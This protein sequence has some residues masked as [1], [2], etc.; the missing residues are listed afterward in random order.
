[1]LAE[2]YCPSLFNST[3]L[4][5]DNTRL[6]K[7]EQRARMVFPRSSWIAAIALHDQRGEI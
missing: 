5:L 7:Q 2:S 6:Q 1:M 3:P 4:A